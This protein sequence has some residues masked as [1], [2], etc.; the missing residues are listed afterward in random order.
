M[1][2]IYSGKV[3]EIYD[4]SD[5]KLVIVTTDRIS[6]FDQ[7][8]PQT[9]KDK[10]IILNR[11]SNFWF[12]K[13]DR[14]VPN[15]IISENLEDMPDFF[16]KKEFKNRTVLVKKLK[17]IPFEFVVRGYMFGSM[18]SAYQ[19]GIDFCGLCIP[20][21]YREAQKLKTPILTPALKRDTG[22]DEYIDLAGLE[23]Q[24]GKETTRKI[25]NICFRLYDTCAKYA[26][27]RGIIIADTKFEFGIDKDGTL[28]LADELFTPDSSRFWD[29]QEYAVGTSPRSYD[30][31]L[32][33]D[34]LTA[35]TKNGVIPFDSVPENII[36]DTEAIYRKCLIQLTDQASTA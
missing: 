27:S 13:T 29:L 30:K 23:N 34:W 20:H 26:L 6:A 18:W 4:V 12:R 16:Q 19:K 7:I 22:H 21:G 35:H 1:K 11:L 31:Q 36:H 15:H 9:V 32:L 2:P 8:L 28:T 5:D 33:R 14:M 3:R 24:L 25:T 17:M 10:G